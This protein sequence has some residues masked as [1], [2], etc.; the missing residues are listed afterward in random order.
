MGRACVC[1][2]DE[3]L[4]DVIH[5]NVDRYP[6]SVRSFVETRIDTYEL[7]GGLDDR[8]F[9]VPSSINI[10]SPQSENTIDNDPF[11]S[12]TFRSVQISSDYVVVNG[13]R[14]YT[15][16]WKKTTLIRKL[17]LSF[18]VDDVFDWDKKNKYDRKFF[19]I[20]NED[21]PASISVFNDLIS[22]ADYQFDIVGMSKHAA[23]D[24]DSF[25]ERGN[26]KYLILLTPTDREVKD[27]FLD[28][29]PDENGEYRNYWDS[30]NDTKPGSIVGLGD[31]GRGSGFGSA[32]VENKIWLELI[33][34]A[35]KDA[36]SSRPSFDQE[37]SAWLGYTQNIEYDWHDCFKR[38]A[39]GEY[40]S[41]CSYMDMYFNF[42]F[43]KDIYF[44]EGSKL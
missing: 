28:Q 33:R 8:N 27:G 42:V 32:V 13:E 18:N 26:T 35:S 25:F 43:F 12:N 15:Q 20:F 14:I 2:G 5:L 22:G 16:I 44:Q 29:E 41:T 34:P 31:W 40:E 38:I 37:V 1:C 17:A 11:V 4:N 23:V 6:A 30:I 9:F 10:I 19:G 39:D 36:A 21:L 3:C 7:K 24:V